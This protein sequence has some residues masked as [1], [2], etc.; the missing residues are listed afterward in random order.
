MPFTTRIKVR[1][2]D[3]DPAGLVY[4]PVILHYAHI[5]MEEFVEE[6]LGLSYSEMMSSQRIGFPTV[7]SQADFFTPIVYGDEV[8]VKVDVMKFGRSSMTL[9]YT[10]IRVSDEVLCSSITNVHVAMDMESRRPIEITEEQRKA[11]EVS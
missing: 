1:F 11:L 3:A 2:G 5:A 9:R 4:Y 7:N 8:D 10:M 6:S